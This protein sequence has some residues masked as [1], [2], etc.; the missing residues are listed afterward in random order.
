M[1][2]RE[3][4]FIG[5]GGL[6]SHLLRSLLS[7]LGI[8]FGVG[9]VIAMLSIGEG[10]KQEALE[11]IQLMGMH[12]IIIQDVPKNE[13]NKKEKD[14]NFSQG[15]QWADARAIQELNPLVDI[16][17]PVREVQLDIRYRK[18]RTKANIIG[19]T[20]EY[21]MVMNYLACSSS[22]IRWERKLRLATSGSPL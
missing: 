10:A 6:R 9:A 13:E 21:A 20:P 11:Q 7:M 3:N 14:S 4:I 18:E 8:I 5:L 15:L 17:V 12:N 16:C 19:T 1:H 2:Y 22:A